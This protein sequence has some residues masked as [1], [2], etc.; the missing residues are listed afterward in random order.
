MNKKIK[1]N[2]QNNAL[3]VVVIVFVFL[4]IFILGVMVFKGTRAEVE[5]RYKITFDVNDDSGVIDGVNELYAQNDTDKLYLSLEEFE[6][7]NVPSVSKEGYEFTGWWTETTGG[8]M[9]IYP[10]GD[11]R[12]DTVSD[13]IDQGKW[14]LTNDIVLYA[15]YSS[16]GYRLTYNC[17][18]NGGFTKN[19]YMIYSPGDEVNLNKICKKSDDTSN[20]LLINATAWDFVGWTDKKDST[21]KI[22]E[23]TMLNDNTELYAIY[24]KNAKVL[25]AAWDG[26]GATI[27]Q[28]V[29][30]ACTLPEVYNND[31]QDTSCVVNPPVITPP[32]GYVVV[33]WNTNKNA[34]TSSNYYNA[35]KNELTLTNSNDVSMAGNQQINPDDSGEV[36]TWYAIVDTKKYKVTLDPIKGILD[37]SLVYVENGKKD[38][39]IDDALVNEFPLATRYGYTFDGWYTEETDGVKVIDRFGTI[40]NYDVDGFIS[41]GLWNLAD[42]ITLYAHYNKADEINGEEDLYSFNETDEFKVLD[43]KKVVSL[44]ETGMKFSTLMDNIN[45]NGEVLLY[46][47]K[48]NLINEN[49][50]LKTGYKLKLVFG[51][52]EIEYVISVKGDVLGTGDLSRDNAKEIAKHIISK[53]LFKDEFVLMAADY[54]NDGKIKMN[55]VVKLLKDINQ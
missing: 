49:T 45:T 26:N 8:D 52:D 21:T 16:D 1:D 46:D 35:Q 54:N 30:K 32:D 18:E 2:N 41:S 27:S 25:S 24:K 9:V 15:Q 29:P 3:I 36:N 10:T 20:G 48:D 17:S 11:V 6:Y 42:D 19:V 34:K 22:D 44:L 55:D 50:N 13:Y 14:N 31:V 28:T 40:Q 47:S 43:E 38:V 39:Y 23:F 33:G 4:L 37:N 5:M 12:D 53:D 51:E 7:G